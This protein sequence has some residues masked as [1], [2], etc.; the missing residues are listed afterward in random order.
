MN[1]IKEEKGV[2]GY[3]FNIYINKKI[4]RSIFVQRIKRVKDNKTYL[5]LVNSRC[6]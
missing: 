4:I 6:V 2:Q 1:V 3:Q 5:F